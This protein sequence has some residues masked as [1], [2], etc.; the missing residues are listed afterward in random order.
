MEELL[1]QAGVKAVPDKQRVDRLLPYRDQ[2]FLNQPAP[3]AEWKVRGVF[4]K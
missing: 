3:K 1:A 2:L 4:T